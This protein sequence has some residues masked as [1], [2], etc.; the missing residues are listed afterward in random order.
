MTQHLIVPL[1]PVT[2]E[3][4]PL[5]DLLAVI[6]GMLKSYGYSDAGVGIQVNNGW[7]PV[8]EKPPEDVHVIIAMP[9]GVQEGVYW[10]EMWHNTEAMEL[11]DIT[12]WQPLPELPEVEP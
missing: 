3:P 8:S 9:D 2:S 5:D 10:G 12:H 1:L 7:H 4:K 11:S 6:K